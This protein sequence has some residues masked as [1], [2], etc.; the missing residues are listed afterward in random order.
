MEDE[1]CVCVWGGSSEQPSCPE[2]T[3]SA[4]G[5]GRWDAACHR[6]FILRTSRKGVRDHTTVNQHDIPT[7]LATSQAIVDEKATISDKL[8]NKSKWK[9]SKL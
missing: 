4:E 3:H 5:N 8:K 6:G 1:V 7:D 2:H 9:H